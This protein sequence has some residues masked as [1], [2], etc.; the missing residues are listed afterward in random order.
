MEDNPTLA[1]QSLIFNFFFF[2]LPEVAMISSSL[3]LFEIQVLSSSSSLFSRAQIQI[4]L[5]LFLQYSLSK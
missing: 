1:A 2:I 3:L 4:F 5:P